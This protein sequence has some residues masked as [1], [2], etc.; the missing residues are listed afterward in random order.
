MT[1]VSRLLRSVGLRRSLATAAVAMMAAVGW[2]AT[3]AHAQIGIV[4]QLP[5]FS[6]TAGTPTD[7]NAYAVTASAVNYAHNATVRVDV[8]NPATHDGF[9]ATT[10]SDAKGGFTKSVSI[11]A[12][13]LGYCGYGCGFAATLNVSAHFY[14]TAAT[15]AY[16]T[17]TRS[18]QVQRAW[19]TG[20]SCD[21]SYQTGSTIS[22]HGQGWTPFA[23]LRIDMHSTT[24]QTSYY[25]AS[26]D[27][28]GNFSIGGL[29]PA[30][31]WTGMTFN[32]YEYSAPQ[33]YAPAVAVTQGPT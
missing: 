14:A 13:E 1:Q 26:A 10:T 4:L 2:P 19:S 11:P 16:D 7:S 27:Q 6:V 30:G 28:F 23:N 32:T 5:I 31:P 3:Q 12:S 22:I 18:V 29:Q 24:G 9:S 25:W 15:A 8:S 21:C 20:I 33:Y 17:P